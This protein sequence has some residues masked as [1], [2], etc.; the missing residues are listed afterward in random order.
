MLPGKCSHLAKLFF[1]LIY[2]PKPWGKRVDCPENLRCYGNFSDVQM[3]SAREDG[4]NMCFV[5]KQMISLVHN[6]VKCPPGLIESLEHRILRC[7][8]RPPPEDNEGIIHEAL[9]S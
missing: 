9:T 5:I 2:G 8:G 7:F 4:N 6:G 1:R 3:Q